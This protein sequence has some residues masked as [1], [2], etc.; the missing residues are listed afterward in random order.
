MHMKLYQRLKAPTPAFFQKVRAIG[1][2]LAG[3]SAAILATPSV[4]PALVVQIA[5]YLAVAGSVATTVSQVATENE[6][7]K[8]EKGG[9]IGQ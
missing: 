7:E 3:I 5:G 2:T 4:F 8:T 6:S 9:L 1:L